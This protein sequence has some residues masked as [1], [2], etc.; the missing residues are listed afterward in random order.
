MN[1]WS[2]VLDSIL[3]IIPDRRAGGPAAEVAPDPVVTTVDLT[4][5]LDFSAPVSP[6]MLMRAGLTPAPLPPMSIPTSKP[7]LPADMW[8]NGLTPAAAMAAHSRLKAEHF[9]SCGADATGWFVR[10]EESKYRLM[11]A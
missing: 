9:C 10:C 2:N 6:D 11:I 4:A 3:D 7:P 5:D 1:D 8:L